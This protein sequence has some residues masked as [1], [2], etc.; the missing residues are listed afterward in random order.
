MAKK[1]LS[2]KAVMADISTEGLSD[3][4]LMKKYELSSDSLQ[5]LFKK[6]KDAGLLT[7]AMLAERSSDFHLDFDV[8]V[9]PRPAPRQKPTQS[10]G[11]QAETSTPTQ[12]FQ[13]ALA[14]NPPPPE[15]AS[16]IEGGYRVNIGQYFSDGWSL[17]TRNAGGFI[18][19]T[20]IFLLISWVPLLNFVLLGGYYV[21]A[22]KLLKGQQPQFGD[23]FKGFDQFVPLLLVGLISGA[24]GSVCSFPLLLERLIGTFLAA[25]GFML[26]LIPAT[27]LGVSYIFACP[28]VIAKGMPFWD[29]METSR[30][31]ITRNFFP[32]LGLALLAG[33]GISIGAL[34]CG[35][36][37]LVTF[38]V[39]MCVMA[40][41]YSDIVGLD[42][43]G[44]INSTGGK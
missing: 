20:V 17:F 32:F 26:L 5:N 2:A 15:L 43:A 38:P 30:K 8:P 35:L 1:Q 19:Y 24:I 31:L 36:G 44:E 29:A 28:L 12:S 27:Y 14:A 34:L 39:S 11:S 23:F 7:D 42:A 40:A 33:V 6:L 10:P 41:A 16:L 4:E 3:E 21:V 25:V 18:G 13:A 37:L 22:F 9:N